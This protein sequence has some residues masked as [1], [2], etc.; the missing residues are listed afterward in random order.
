MKKG[1]SFF[2]I[3]ISII[4]LV[5]CTCKISLEDTDLFDR[6]EVST[7]DNQI[8]LIIP[9]L[10]NDTKY[11]NVFRQEGDSTPVNIGIIYPNALMDKNYFFVDAFTTKQHK[12][13][14]R[15]RYCDSSGYQYSKWSEVISTKDENFAHDTT[16]RMKYDA[17]SVK[18]K[19]DKDEYTLTIDGTI[20]SPNFTEFFDD[21]MA[22]ADDTDDLEKPFAF[23]PM[24][25]ISNSERTEAI[26]FSST[27]NGTVIP[28]RN[29]LPMYFLDTNITIKG[30][31]AKQN[32]YKK[33][34]PD[35]ESELI[36]EYIIWLE[37][38]D[39]NVTGAGSSKIINI[40]SQI[41]DNGLD[42]NPSI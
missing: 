26:Q 28:L 7:K 17:S 13:K 38:A 41:G 15:V 24:L 25:I 9:R 30:L 2:Y 12:Y 16:E 23:K 31:I 29:I 27:A 33:P 3:F 42:Y 39:I 32:K 8:S 22:D 18:F 34:Y 5:L 40:P 1:T 21:D 6:P 35:D 10:N 20:Q 37:P 14:Y 11:I 36:T 4:S 19:Y